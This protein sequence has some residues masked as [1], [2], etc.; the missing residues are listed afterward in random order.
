MQSALHTL[1]VTWCDFMVAEMHHLL[2][3]KDQHLG[4]NFGP[5]RAHTERV[6]ALPNVAKYLRTRKPY[7]I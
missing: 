7:P 1:Q 3:Q 5:L 6:M 4:D 2:L